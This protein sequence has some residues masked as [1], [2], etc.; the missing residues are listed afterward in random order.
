MMEEVV[1]P[2]QESKGMVITGS[3]RG[4]TDESIY[5]WMRR[6]ASEEQRAAQ[7]AAVYESDFWKKTVEPRVPEFLDE[8]GI[9]VTRIVPTSAQLSLSVGAIT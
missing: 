2:F 9:V 6:F 1:I 4:E 8:E 5:I 7:Y 3:F